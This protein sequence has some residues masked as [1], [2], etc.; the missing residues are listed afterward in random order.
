MVV[1]VNKKGFM[2]VETIIM[3]AILMVGLLIIYNSFTSSIAK[4]KERLNYYS[5]SN[6]YKLYYVK[7]YLKNKDIY[8]WLCKGK[9][10]CPVDDEIFSD[11]EYID[12]NE[13]EYAK[14]IL[15][16]LDIKRIYLT[17]CDAEI[18]LSEDD[19]FKTYLDTLKVCKKYRFVAEFYDE[20]TKKYSYGNLEYPLEGKA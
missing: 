4:Q 9:D 12:I 19:D 20:I 15:E 11:K 10:Y 7:S 17:K 1:I 2:F 6:T 16:I 5:I 18:P 3:C 14:E 13:D 8:L